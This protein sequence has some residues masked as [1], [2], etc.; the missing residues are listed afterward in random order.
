MASKSGQSRFRTRSTLGRFLV[1]KEK[2]EIGAFK[3]PGLRNVELTAPYMHD[4]SEAT[5]EAV[6]EFYNKGGTA[7]PFLDELMQPLNLTAEEKESII[8]FLHTLTDWEFVESEQF[9]DPFEGNER[10]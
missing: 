3:T 6:V 8:A 9:A 7:N 2:A 4:G 1:T 5:L 10:Q